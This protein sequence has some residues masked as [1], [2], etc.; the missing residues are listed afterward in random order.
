MSTK[1]SR[2]VFVLMLL[3]GSVRLIMQGQFFLST[4]MEV[5]VGLLNSLSCIFPFFLGLSCCDFLP[6]MFF[7]VVLLFIRTF[8]HFHH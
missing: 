4:S 6:R 7:S 2:G 8:Y 3:H 5:A 1:V